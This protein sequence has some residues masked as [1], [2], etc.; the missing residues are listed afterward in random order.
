MK[1]AA[2]G[3][4]RTKMTEAMLGAFLDN[5]LRRCVGFGNSGD[6]I[7]AAREKAL[8]YYF[9][10]PRGD[11]R[12]G[13]S[14]LQSSDVQDV[15]EAFLPGLLAPFISSDKVVEFTPVSKE[16]EDMSGQATATVNNVLM[17]DNDGVKI[18][19]TWAKDALLQKN[20]FVY[21][22]WS[23]IE[24]TRRLSQRVDMAG[25]AR[26]RDDKENEILQ[27]AAFD[28]AGMGIAPELVEAGQFGEDAA[29]EVD[30]RRTWVEGVD[31]VRNIAP[32]NM[33]I[34]STASC[35]EDARVVG[36]REKVTVSDLRT[37][38]YDDDLVERVEKGATDSPND[39][40]G[41]Y[42]SRW[43]E[44]GGYFEQGDGTASTDPAARVV[45]RTVLW[46]RVDFDGDG[47]T[48]M[49]KIIRAGLGESG[50]VVLYNEE[51]DD[52]P[53][54]TFTPIPNPH[55][56]FGNSFSDLTFQ[57]QDSKTSLR[58]L[59]MDGL[60]H[61]VFPRNLVNENMTVDDT[62]DDLQSNVPGSSIRV[63]GDGAVI[64][65]RESV[66][67]GGIFQALEYEDRVRDTRTPVTRD[68]QGV[69]PNI[70][71]DRTAREAT[72][73]ANASQ[74]RQELIMRLF[75]EAV[76]K[77]CK[78]I[79][80]QLIKHQ[81]KPRTIRLT[82]RWVE[83]DPRYWNADMDVT[84]NV[85]LGTGTKDQQ[86]Q[87]LMT[88]HGIQMGDLQMGLP[89]VD[90][91]KLYNTR[92]RIIE[93]AGLSTPET[94]FNN[95]SNPGNQQQGQP[96]PSPEDQQAQAAQAQEQQKAEADKIQQA[97]DAAREEGRKEANLELEHMKMQMQ[98]QVKAAELQASKEI[99]TEEIASKER[100]HQKDLDMRGVE[101]LS[102][103]ATAQEDRLM[104]QSN[105]GGIS[106]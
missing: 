53:I 99:K 75:A 10:R 94:Y 41:E 65:Y 96:S 28:G 90:M 36:W 88:V 22:D 98:I 105:Q 83:V 106:D 82:N 33:L 1:T 51:V 73:Q 8:D 68:M 74:Q 59:G 31:K 29:F 86:L 23:E 52:A 66:E 26:I 54:V 62:W 61:T 15:I 87:S 38:G 97:I 79:L 57:I 35:I 37:E 39:L 103:H 30:Y 81:D 13:H 2:Q 50:G 80:K 4:K 78:I 48:E 91:E 101:I 69:D 3:K 34:S 64:P 49:R 43:R 85:G 70:L 27:V 60:Y 9:N 55:V 63:G 18:L 95:P 76:G 20:G 47:K 102:N 16:D 11:E 5:E 7:S 89:T 6:E 40:S 32:E 93:N 84:A 14:K 12:V 56:V 46:T 24:R 19:Y 77:L 17:V 21:A 58:R 100:M 67:L 45:W 71:N 92:A 42:A 104:Q 25:L 44:Q 72:I